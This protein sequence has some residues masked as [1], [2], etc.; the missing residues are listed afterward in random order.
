[1]IYVFNRV[2]TSFS[3]QHVGNY[4]RAKSVPKRIADL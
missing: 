2:Q 4:I 3:R 1:M